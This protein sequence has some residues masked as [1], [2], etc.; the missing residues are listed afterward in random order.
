[1]KIE[2]TPKGFHIRKTPEMVLR[3]DVERSA[4]IREDLRLKMMRENL[5]PGYFRIREAQE[6]LGLSKSTM[7]RLLSGWI[8]EGSLETLGESRGRLY[9]FARTNSSN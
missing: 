5:G 2:Y 8:E 3:V 6:L 1:M 9:R 4:E 7:Q